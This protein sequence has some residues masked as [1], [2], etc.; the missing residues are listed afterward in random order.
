M[1][2]HHVSTI[3]ED[4]EARQ[5]LIFQHALQEFCVKGYE[6]TS[7]S[8]IASSVGVSEA[9]LYK[10]V[11]GKQEL[12]YRAIALGYEDE[13]RLALEEVEAWGGEGPHA[14]KLEAFIRAHV[15]RWSCNPA[16]HLLYFHESRKPKTQFTSLLA[17]KSRQYFNLLE[18]ILREG[19]QSGE[20]MLIE[21]IP[22]ACDIIIGGIDQALW[23]RAE[24]KLHIDTDEIFPKICNIYMRTFLKEQDHSVISL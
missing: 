6:G 19:A 8:S 13:F 9:L 18:G 3:H 12:L 15:L 24:R 21:D 20:F 17:E 10:H 2:G 4:Y 23:W 11:K 14:K 16:F 22:L 7:I 1:S 5:I